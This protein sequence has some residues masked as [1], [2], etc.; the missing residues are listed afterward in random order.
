M[1]TKTDQGK[2]IRPLTPPHAPTRGDVHLAEYE[3]LKAEQRDRITGR[4][5]LFW[6]VFLAVGVIGYQALS[7]DDPHRLLAI[8]AVVTVVGWLYITADRKITA[9][10]RYFHSLAR[11]LAIETGSAPDEPPLLAW[12]QPSKSRSA[13]QRGFQLWVLLSL[14]AAPGIVAVGAWAYLTLP[15]FGPPAPTLAIVAAIMTFDCVILAGAFVHNAFARL[16]RPA[17]TSPTA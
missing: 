17:N 7:T 1:Y 3:Q 8:P 12:E 10:R 15:R 14:Y 11:E 9:L 2:E 16:D 5:R 4:D 13:L 6:F